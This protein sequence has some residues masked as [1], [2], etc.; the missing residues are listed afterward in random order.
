MNSI[1]IFYLVDSKELN[2]DDFN[3]LL[4]KPNIPYNPNF[5]EVKELA[6]KINAKK[7]VVDTDNQQIIIK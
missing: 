7:I 3:K 4:S 5:K 1:P 2:Y 6:A